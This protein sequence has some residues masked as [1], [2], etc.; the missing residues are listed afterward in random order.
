M[1]SFILVEDNFLSKKYCKYIIDEYKNKTNV[2]L[3]H[4]GYKGYYLRE[5]EKIFSELQLK[6]TKIIKKYVKMYPEINLTKNK[7]AL[8]EITFKHFKPGNFFS[9]YHSEVGLNCS[10]RILNMM[11]YLS[12]HNCGTQFFNKKVIKSRIGRITIFPSYFTHTHRG[13]ICPDNKDRYI[14]GG[15]YNFIDI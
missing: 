12:E 2:E 3:K 13:Q 14:L 4:T 9:D 7:W 5:S 8:T 11:I 15:Y 10:T 1:K 6:I